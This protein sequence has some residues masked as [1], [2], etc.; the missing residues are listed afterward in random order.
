MGGKVYYGIADIESW[1][2]NGI[3]YDKAE[4]NAID[5]VADILAILLLTKLIFGGNQKSPL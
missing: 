3:P 5:N 2:D 4:V 1:E